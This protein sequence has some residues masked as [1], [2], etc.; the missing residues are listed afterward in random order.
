VDWSAEPT[1]EGISYP[2]V[3]QL[4]S[5]E[6]RIARPKGENLFYVLKDG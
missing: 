6:E 1:P 4:L 3:F 5:T 2:R